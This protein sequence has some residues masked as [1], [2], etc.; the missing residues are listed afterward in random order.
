[1]IPKLCRNSEVVVSGLNHQK[2]ATVCHGKLGKEYHV[3]IVDKLNAIMEDV[4]R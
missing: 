1:M 3:Q 4:M 2:Y